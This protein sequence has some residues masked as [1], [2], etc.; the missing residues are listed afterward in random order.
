[1]KDS[2]YFNKYCILSSLSNKTFRENFSC[3][4]RLDLTRKSWPNIAM[5]TVIDDDHAL[6]EL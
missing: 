6:L 3:K 4:F 2:A 5:I 1:M